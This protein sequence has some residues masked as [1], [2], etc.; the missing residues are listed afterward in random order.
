MT[1]LDWE[2]LGF[3]NVYSAEDGLDALKICRNHKI[4]LVLTDIVMPLMDGIELSKVLSTEFP[5]ITIVILTGHEEF[6]YARQSID[7]GVK[8]YILKPVG[9]K[10][11]Y[12]KMSEIC[13]RLNKQASQ[14]EYIAK[15]RAQ[16]H[17]SMPI[18]REKFLYN[19]V[20]T[21][22]NRLRNE[23]ER[24]KELN[25]PLLGSTYVV[26]IVEVDLTQIADSDMG[27][28]L[29]SAKNIS[30]DCVGNNNCVFD[31]NNNR[32]IIIFNPDAYE[33][34]VYD[35]VYR[36][37]QVMQKAINRILKVNIT[38]ALGSIVDMDN[39][40]NSYQEAKTALDCKYTLGT[41]G[42]YSIH[43]LDYIGKQFYYPTE[44]IKELI[45]NV[46][47]LGE[48]EIRDAVNKIFMN[49]TQRKKL[50]GQNLSGQN[51]KMIFIEIVTLLLN[52]LSKIKQVSGSVWEE[53]FL[54][55]N[56]MVQMNKIEQAMKNLTDL[57]I[58]VSREIQ[59]IQSD[60]GQ[61]LIE[62][63]KEYMEANYTD[64]GLSLSTTADYAAVSTGYL[65]ALFKKETGINFIDY[66]T[67]VRMEKAM[68]LLKTTDK[69]TYEI[70]YETGFA[71]PHYFSIS[72][73]KYLGMSPSDYRNKD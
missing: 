19:L 54:A 13:K 59:Q 47:F 40:Y 56:Q 32:I 24:I 6:E 42:V 61:L 46:K 20:C 26:G 70:A 41:D 48:P 60:K 62:R 22:N 68:E 71:N 28:Y 11:L 4:D 27:L 50:D 36:T 2:S 43:D 35:I 63:V 38:C 15:M 65:S 66:L 57:S 37:L 18:V 8:N 51:I 5:E 49:L 1:I 72:F 12:E 55:F 67:N 29:F 73:K 25:L 16:I 7:L 58:K 9:A 34:D 44:I 3:S 64:E 33:E 31:D 10:T 39:L 30:C 17:Q 45:Y 53:G 21:Q 14:K 52:E 23:S 69:K